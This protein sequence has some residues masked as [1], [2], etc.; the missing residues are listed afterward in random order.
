MVGV[1]IAT[2]VVVIV[3]VLIIYGIMKI[4]G[5]KSG[6]QFSKDPSI[7]SLVL[8][9]NQPLPNIETSVNKS[10]LYSIDSDICLNAYD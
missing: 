6:I 10:H 8:N 3:L 2:V 9:D 5:D 7:F 1:I 4:Y